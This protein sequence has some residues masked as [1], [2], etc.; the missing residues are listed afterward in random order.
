M[1]EDDMF[2]D[3][4]DDDVSEYDAPENGFSIELDESDDLSDGDF[5]A[6]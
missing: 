3:D 1:D 6:Y 5:A 4:D 2:D